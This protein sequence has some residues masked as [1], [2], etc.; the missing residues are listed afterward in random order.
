MTN[1]W[2][3]ETRPDSY[4]TAEVIRALGMGEHTCTTITA[5][6]LAGLEEGLE[7]MRNSLSKTASRAQAL[8]GNKYATRVFRAIMKDGAVGGVLVTRTE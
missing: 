4:R 1:N 8:T 5:R 2:Q 3:L 6:D 7:A